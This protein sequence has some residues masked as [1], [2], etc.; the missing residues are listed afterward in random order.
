VY[1]WADENASF[2]YQKARGVNAAPWG[3]K[4]LPWLRSATISPVTESG[5]A[6]Y[7]RAAANYGQNASHVVPADYHVHGTMNPIR[8]GWYVR[9][10]DDLTFRIAVGGGTGTAHL[11]VFGNL[12]I[13]S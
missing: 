1:A 5:F 6:W 3:F 2:S 9:Y 13:R 7:S 4:L 11:Y 12:S 8:P 10:S